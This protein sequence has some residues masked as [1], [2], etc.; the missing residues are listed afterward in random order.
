MKKQNKSLI[1]GVFTPIV[2]CATHA[3]NNKHRMQMKQ[4][5]HFKVNP[6]WIQFADC[7]VNRKKKNPVQTRLTSGL[8]FDADCIVVLSVFA[9]FASQIESYAHS[10]YPVKTYHFRYYVPLRGK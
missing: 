6:V 8:K 9:L 10:Q 4:V 1:N 7:S 2:K 5:Q 3:A